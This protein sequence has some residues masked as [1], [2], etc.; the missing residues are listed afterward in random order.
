MG[1]SAKGSANIRR[2]V[3][4]GWGEH[5]ERRELRTESV[6]SVSCVWSAKSDNKV[7]GVFYFLGFLFF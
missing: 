1:K 2:E 7:S 6:K 3:E 5:C 4:C